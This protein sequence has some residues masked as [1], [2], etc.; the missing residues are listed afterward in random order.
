[1]N[2]RLKQCEVIVKRTL[3]KKQPIE[4][5]AMIGVNETLNRQRF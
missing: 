5:D 3:N 4:S 1:V 2:V